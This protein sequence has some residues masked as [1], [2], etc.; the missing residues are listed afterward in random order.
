[1]SNLEDF[2]FFYKEAFKRNIG[3]LTED[4]QA[5]LCSA[6]IGI[7]GLGGV[8]GNYLISLVRLG[9]RNFHIADG[10]SFD[11]VNIQRQYGATINTLGRNKAEVMRELALSINPHLNLKVFSEKID[12]NNIDEFLYGLDIVID[13]ID[14]FSIEDRRFLF[15]KAKD[16]GIF[17]LTAAPLGFGVS[18]L[19][20]S[21]QGMSFDEYF[22]INDKMSY[23]EKLV[24]FGIGL[25]P[26]GFHLKYIKLNSVDIDKKQGPSLVSSCNLCSSIILTEV[27]NIIL[28]KRKIYSVPNYFLF[29]PYL[30]KFKK[31]Y[32]LLGNRNPL[33]RFK[34]WYILKKISKKIR[35]NV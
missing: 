32:L 4:D 10:D 14:F 13:G 1:M 21:P 25:S 35:E 27:I 11:I 7:V 30:R 20:F 23:L 5:K 34:R 17:V 8:G 22:D 2:E 29:D 28:K 26:S 31:G 19:I 24:S 16:K 6:K 18:L 33:Q 3:I 9:I 15:N 12:S